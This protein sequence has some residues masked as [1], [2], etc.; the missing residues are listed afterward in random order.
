MIK[1]KLAVMVHHNLTWSQ[2]HPTGYFQSQR[3]EASVG[4]QTDAHPR[5]AV[6]GLS[7]ESRKRNSAA[8]RLRG[9]LAEAFPLALLMRWEDQANPHRSK[10]VQTLKG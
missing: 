5:S 10:L 2:C 4:R 6:T 7:A 8:S 9:V 1:Q 3:G